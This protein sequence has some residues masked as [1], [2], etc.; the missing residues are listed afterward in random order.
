MAEHDH[1]R[2]GY[3]S[4][5][6]SP[7]QCPYRT[8]ANAGAPPAVIEEIEVPRFVAHE[9]IV[10][11]TVSIQAPTKYGLYSLEND[12]LINYLYS[13]TARLEMSRYYNSTSS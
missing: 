5:R 7:P 9:G 2:D 6:P 13:P 11:G 8:L 12:K 10:R 4:A 1:V 3:K